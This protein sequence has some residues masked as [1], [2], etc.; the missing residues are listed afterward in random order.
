MV[1]ETAYPQLVGKKE[2][3]KLIRNH[4]LTAGLH[5]TGSLGGMMTSSGLMGNRTT[6][7]G[8]MFL[9]FIERNE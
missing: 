5:K 9:N 6:E 1:Q 7:F 8:K 4:L 2:F 3:Y